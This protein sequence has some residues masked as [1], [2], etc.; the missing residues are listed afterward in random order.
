MPRTRTLLSAAVRYFGIVF[1][2]GFLLGVVR[3]LWLVPRV[4]ERTAELMEIPL[5]LAVILLAARRV[6]RR[7]RLPAGPAARLPVGALA[8]ALMV[9]AEIALVVGRGFTL[10]EYVA[11]RDPVSGAAYLASLGLFALMPW[12]LAPARSDEHAPQEVG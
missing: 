4:G 10:A 7:Q 2:A 11:L 3:V 6:A 5:M 12:L 8:L 9:G 1:A